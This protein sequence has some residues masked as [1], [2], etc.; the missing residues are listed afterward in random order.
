MR[1]VSWPDVEDRLQQKRIAI[2]GGGP[3]AV[4]NEPGLIDDHDIVV[5]VN[6]Y[7]TGE[8]QG[9]RCDVFYSFF[10]GSIKKTVEEL[11]RDGVTLCICKCPNS[12]PIQSAWHE[13]HRKLNGIDYRYIYATRRSWW[14]C[15]TFVPDDL[16]F[17]Q[18]FDLLERHIASTGFAAILDVL[19]CAPKSVY[20]TGFDFFESKL[21]SVNEP[22]REGDLTDPIRHRPDLEMA[23]LLKHWRSLPI[24][25]DR[26]L[27]ERLKLAA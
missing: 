23:W 7:K 17:L 21:H 3:T 16:H 1:F 11:T 26:S 8:G 20:L 4:E 15:D 22:W 13:T 12:R 2:V 24:T 10:G 18:T 9:K 27:T 5:R 6:N 14:F 25:L 19:A